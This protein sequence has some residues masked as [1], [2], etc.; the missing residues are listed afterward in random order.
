ML[1]DRGVSIMAKVYSK[2]YEQG[3][4]KKYGKTRK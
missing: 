2:S 3:G 1:G 4:Q